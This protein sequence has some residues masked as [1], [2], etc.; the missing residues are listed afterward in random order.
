LREKHLI[1]ELKHTTINTTN[2]TYKNLE[3]ICSNGEKELIELE[4]KRVIKKDDLNKK[5][6]SKIYDEIQ[7]LM[8]S[9]GVLIFG[10]AENKKNR[11]CF[12]DFG[13]LK[14][15]Q[16]E[17]WFKN[18][19]RN[20]KVEDFL[21][22]KV[23]KHPKEPR[24]FLIV[25]IPKNPKW[26]GNP[27]TGEFWIRLYD[28]KGSP[29]LSRLEPE[30]LR[31]LF[32]DYEFIQDEVE[33]VLKSIQTLNCLFTIPFDAKILKK[34]EPL[35]AFLE[36][37]EKN[38]IIELKNL[39]FTDNIQYQDNGKSYSFKNNKLKCERCP[40]Y[41]FSLNLHFDKNGS[42]RFF[43]KRITH[44]LLAHKGVARKLNLKIIYENIQKIIALAKQYYGIF[45]IN[46]F[47][48]GFYLPHHA[49]IRAIG[50]ISLGLEKIFFKTDIKFDFDLKITKIN[51]DTTSLVFSKLIDRMIRSLNTE[52]V[53]IEVFKQE[54][55]KIIN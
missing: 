13:V 52:N 40:E 55:N 42:I 32:F 49:N 8:Y 48:I 2:I 1:L 45:G 26:K 5:F 37:I 53:P 34:R 43:D 12:D 29:K 4:F 35:E 6:S 31:K 17:T 19:I 18:F 36:E 47:K 22:Y 41:S 9:G 14:D 15:C 27:E 10:I 44:S 51:K 33:N 25:N 7:A 3:S 28:H 50:N 11:A 46:N 39:L 30:R 24:E 21:S 20:K 16:I 38:P 23:I 54:I